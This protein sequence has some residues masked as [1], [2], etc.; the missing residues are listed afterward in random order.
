[1]LLRLLLLL[2]VAWLVWLTWRK[3]KPRD[4]NAAPPSAPQ[5]PTNG[6]EA[7][8][9]CAEC[10]VHLPDSQALPGRGGHFCSTAHRERYEA[11]EPR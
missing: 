9:R 1:M 5:A 2:L 4:E 11:R 10:G 3:L 6:P 8:R 7:M